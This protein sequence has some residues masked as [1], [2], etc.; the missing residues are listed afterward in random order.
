MNEVFT[1]EQK[2]LIDQP[3]LPRPEQYSPLW[4]PQSYSAVPATSSFP[5]TR[6]VQRRPFST[7]TMSMTQDELERKVMTTG[8]VI[9][10]TIPEKRY[11]DVL[12]LLHHF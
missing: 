6:R 7:E 1:H 4:G 2:E 11:L 8:V 3:K 12:R 9:G 10:P 5:V